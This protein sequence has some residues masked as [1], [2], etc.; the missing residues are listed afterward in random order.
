M[1]IIQRSHKLNSESPH[2]GIGDAA[3]PEP[4]AEA[5]ESLA[6]ELENKAD[7]RAVGA[8]ML[9][10]VQHMA[11]VLVSWM[12][13]ISVSQMGQDFLLK[14]VISLA[15]ALGAEYFKSFECVSGVIPVILG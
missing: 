8:N 14:G 2:E 10:T 13:A 1:S 11:D 6:H 4:A 5:G 9:E 12:L 15:I 7:V 3:S